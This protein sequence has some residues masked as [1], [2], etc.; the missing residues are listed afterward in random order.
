MKALIKEITGIIEKQIK[1]PDRTYILKLEDFNTPVIYAEFGMDF[2]SKSYLNFIANLE[3]NKYAYFKDQD[4]PDWIPA[5]EYL[6]NNGYAKNEPLTYFR[7]QAATGN[8]ETTLLLLMGAESA[9][10]KGSLKDF[11]HISMNDIVECLKKNYSTWFTDLLNSFQC[12]PDKGSDCINNI[13]KDLFRHINIDAMKLS[14]F[15]DDLDNHDIDT[16]EGLVDHIYSSLQN[17]WDIP[18][19]RT[20]IKIPANKPLKYISNSYQF[21]NNSCYNIITG[22]S[23][24]KKVG[25]RYSKFKL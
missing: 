17:Y 23:T 14:C 5:L 11:T 18:S 15:V 10:D 2:S 4:K 7:N 19:I 1:F 6:S 12:D 25:R 3:Y 20:N 8:T 9:L 13:Y 16:L 22:K 24:R 21:I